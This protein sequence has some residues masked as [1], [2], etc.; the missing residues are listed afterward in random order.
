MLNFLFTGLWLNGYGLNL[1]LVQ[2]IHTSHRK[3]LKYDRIVHFTNAL[4]RVDH[5]A[6]ITSDLK[7]IRKILSE[8]KV[9]FKEDASDVIGIEQIFLFDPDGN[10]IEISNCSPEIGKISCDS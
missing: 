8:A 1:H 10:V 3:Q 4:P 6:F 7:F 5:I 2:T 9:Y